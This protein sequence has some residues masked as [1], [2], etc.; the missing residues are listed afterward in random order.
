MANKWNNL[1]R[2]MS[3]QAQTRVDSRVKAT[4]Q[5]MPLAEIRKAIGM[6]QADLA[7]KLDVAQGSVS[8]FENAAD[9]YLTTLRKYVEALG[10]ELHL[11]AKFA[12]GRELEIQHLADMAAR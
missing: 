2:K 3:P 4:L 1:K 7:G 10:G 5:A 9:M 11:T 6:T 8:K 12:D